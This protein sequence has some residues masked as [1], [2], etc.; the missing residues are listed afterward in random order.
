MFVLYWCREIAK[1]S[2]L[3]VHIDTGFVSAQAL[4]NV[5]NAIS[6]LGV[7]YVNIELQDDLLK[8]LYRLFLAK[9][10]DFCTPCTAGLRATIRQ[11]A[12]E[13]DIDLI[14]TGS[15]PQ[16]EFSPYLAYSDDDYFLS[17]V[18]NE[19]PREKLRPY[20]SKPEERRVRTLALPY[21]VVWNEEKIGHLIKHRI[22]WRPMVDHGD[23]LAS[24]VKGYLWTRRW[25]FAKPTVKL[26][27][28]I[29]QGHITRKEALDRIADEEPRAEP[30]VLPYFLNELSMSREE[31]EA[32][33]DVDVTR[34]IQSHWRSREG[35]GKVRR[36]NPGG[37]LGWTPDIVQICARWMYG[38]IIMPS[39]FCRAMRFVGPEVVQILEQY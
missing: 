31:F 11:F 9:T 39:I 8:K 35:Q 14:V 30:P 25:G 18:G 1:L 38:H 33:A 32:A 26:S 13:N 27:A 5:Q 16:E 22:G 23:C 37:L 7:D 10:G 4:E 2:I 3:A 34:V 15:S 19:I 21:Y 12:F 6:A 17:M 29:R 36:L 24:P 20:V 28:M